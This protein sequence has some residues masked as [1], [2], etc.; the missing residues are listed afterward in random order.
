MT[1][2]RVAAAE[3]QGKCTCTTYTQT[4]GWES[5]KCDNCGVNPYFAEHNTPDYP[6]DANAA[7]SL[8]NALAEQGWMWRVDGGKGVVGVI[9]YKGTIGQDYQSINDTGP[10]LSIA[11]C[12][13]YLAVVQSQTHT[14]TTQVGPQLDQPTEL[15]RL[16]LVLAKIAHDCPCDNDGQGCP[17]VEIAKE[18]LHPNPMCMCGHPLKDHIG[19]LMFCPIKDEGDV[20]QCFVLNDDWPT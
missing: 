1:P 4:A 8:C 15:S 5:A 3:A 7:E 9:F 18:A 19:E 20:A 14:T 11:I 6:T 10:T 17:C 12:R 2:I 16:R 13:A